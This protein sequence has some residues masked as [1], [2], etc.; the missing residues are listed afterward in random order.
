MKKKVIALVLTGIMGISLMA[1][2]QEKK[3]KPVVQETVEEESMEEEQ[4]VQK[5]QEEQEA[6]TDVPEETQ[7]EE[8]IQEEI[9]YEDNFSV[10]SEDFSCYNVTMC[11]HIILNAKI[12]GIRI[13]L[14]R[15]S[16]ALYRSGVNTDKMLRTDSGKNKKHIF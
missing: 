15:K 6:Q 5:P 4:E 10:D 13:Y 3:E 11:F 16:F 8:N 12:T 2:G 9:K 1:C 14:P 7:G